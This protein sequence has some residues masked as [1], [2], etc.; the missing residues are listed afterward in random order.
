MKTFKINSEPSYSSM[1][2]RYIKK[3]WFSIIILGLFLL[4]LDFRELAWLKVPLFILSFLIFGYGYGY[5]TSKVIYKISIDLTNK[6]VVLFHFVLFK[7]KTIIPF[8]KLHFECVKIKPTKR[9]EEI[10]KIYFKKSPGLSGGV[11]MSSAKQWS[12]NK[13]QLV[14]IS[15]LLHNVKS[16]QETWKPE[17]TF[18]QEPIGKINSFVKVDYFVP[19]SEDL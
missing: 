8:P 13:K 9:D 10:W 18:L 1:L 14:V 2:Y 12:W 7:D 5:S 11:I 17:K 3:Y 15:K 6:R 19:A 16:E 4:V